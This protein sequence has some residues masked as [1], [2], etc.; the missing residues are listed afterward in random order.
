MPC[1]SVPTALLIGGGVSAAAGIASSVIGGNAAKSAAQTQATAA[2]QAAQAQMDM[3]NTTNTNL[4]PY[5]TAGVNAL[6]G[7]EDLLGEGPN[8]TAGIM[9]QLQSMPGYQF[10]L[11]QGLQATQ[12]GYAA[13]G[14]GQSGSALKGA[15]SYAEGLAGTQYQ[16]LFGNALSTAE[17]GENAAAQ[18]GT[19]GQSAALNASNFNTSGAAATAAG[20]VGSA[21]AIGA[22]INAIGGAANNTALL[23][24]LQNAGMFGA[25]A[26]GTD[27]SLDR[28]LYGS[29]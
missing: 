23:L 7:V 26:T 16:S 1:I 22:G 8:G 27:N 9:T 29:L 19:I 18:T 3:F 13:Q 15:A 5:R 11:Q 12:N 20:Q 4:A 10:T 14:L 17:L 2:E 24:A 28:A 25:P 6:G 21:N